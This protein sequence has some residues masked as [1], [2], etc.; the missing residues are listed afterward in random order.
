M[1]DRTLSIP[2]WHELALEGT[3][4]PMRIL[5]HGGSMMPL[6]RRGRDYVTIVPV[7]GRLAIGDIVLFSDPHKER[8]VLHRVWKLDGERVQTWG[9]SCESPDA[10]LQTADVWGKAVLIERGR[11]R[12]IPDPR[13]GR[14]LARIWHVVGKVRRK[15]LSH[16]R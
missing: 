8:Y 2:E 14:A 12:I 11:R 6:I 16:H 4:L 7:S 10:W 15:A 1:A 3:M 9:D 13:K 5:I